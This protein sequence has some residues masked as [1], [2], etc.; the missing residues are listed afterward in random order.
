MLS[1]HCLD[2]IIVFVSFFQFNKLEFWVKP[3]VP[4][5][6]LAVVLLNTETFGNGSPVSISAD[7]VGMVDPRGYNVTEVF[8]GQNLGI[9][10][11]DTTFTTHVYPTSVYMII[12]KILP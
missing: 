10:K 11:P 8:E 1:L 12:C 6:S 4:K 5:G 7:E 9:F 2:N 3:I